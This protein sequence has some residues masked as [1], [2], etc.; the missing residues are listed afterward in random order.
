MPGIEKSVLQPDRALTTH[1]PKWDALDQCLKD[2]TA[3]HL[4]NPCWSTEACV[5]FA[6]LN[7]LLSSSLN[8]LSIHHDKAH[9]KTE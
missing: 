5:Y 2:V 9:L 3:L 4:R 6:L 1:N 8:A 7:T